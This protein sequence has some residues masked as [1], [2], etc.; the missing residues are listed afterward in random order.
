[1]NNCFSLIVYLSLRSF[2]VLIFSQFKRDKIALIEVLKS[3]GN[4]MKKLDL[5]N[6]EELN[7]EKDM[8]HPYV[9]F[10][11]YDNKE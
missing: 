3:P 9:R 7:K 6:Q 2:S 8:L 10:L 5:K 4:H 1:M 11:G